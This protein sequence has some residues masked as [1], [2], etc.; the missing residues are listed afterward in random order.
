MLSSLRP[1]SAQSLSAQVLWARIFGLQG[2]DHDAVMSWSKVRAQC[3][4]GSDVWCQSMLGEAAAWVRLSDPQQA[5]RLLA[6]L[7]GLG[8][9]PLPVDVAD[10]LSNL[11]RSLEDRP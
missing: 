1:E 9:D 3:A 2:K 6:Q 11:E 8:P 5:S 4:V 7:R 10:R